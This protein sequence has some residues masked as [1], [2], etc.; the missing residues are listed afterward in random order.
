M[1]LGKAAVSDLLKNAKLNG[2]SST[3]IVE[4]KT[5]LERACGGTLPEEPLW[6]GIKFKLEPSPRRHYNSN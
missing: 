6:V 4:D 2:S 3:S 1:F 5:T